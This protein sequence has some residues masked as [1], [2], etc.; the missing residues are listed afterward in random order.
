MSA[1]AVEIASRLL[2]EEMDRRD[3]GDLSDNAKDVAAEFLGQIM[4]A[5][6]K[7]KERGH[8][9]EKTRARAQ[10]IWLRACS[11]DVEVRERAID[12]LVLFVA[13]SEQQAMA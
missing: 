10:D 13:D 11:G 1:A 7:L 12:D 2:R 3:L 4:V 9:M 6:I 5:M 8:D